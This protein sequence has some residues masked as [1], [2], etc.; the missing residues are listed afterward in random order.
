MSSSV[1][2]DQKG[3]LKIPVILLSNARKLGTGFYITSEIGDFV[4]IYPLHVWEEI[5]ERLARL[6]SHNT[7]G[8][9]LLARAKYFGETVSI[10]K[11]GRLLIPVVLRKIAKM[12]GEVDVLDYPNYLE[13]WNHA[14][15]VDNHKRSPIT[16]NDAKTLEIYLADIS[17]VRKASR[18]G[19][20]PRTHYDIPTCAEG[21]TRARICRTIGIFRFGYE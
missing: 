12:R 6:S 7:N 19:A 1:K 11:Q 8:Q 5:I 16:A 18:K 20:R 4:R 17:P 13:V 9:K 14:R 2:V 10:D 3:R 21:P 15:L